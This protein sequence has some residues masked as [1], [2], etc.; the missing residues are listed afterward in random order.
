MVPRVDDTI[1]EQMAAAYTVPYR[2]ITGHNLP[3]T[4][5]QT[6]EESVRGYLNR[7]L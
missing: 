3:R 1:I 2:M 5:L 7:M 6:I 4:M